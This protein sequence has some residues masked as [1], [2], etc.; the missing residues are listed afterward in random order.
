MTRPA[1]FDAFDETMIAEPDAALPGRAPTFMN[2]VR[3]RP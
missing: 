3:T 2:P 1:A